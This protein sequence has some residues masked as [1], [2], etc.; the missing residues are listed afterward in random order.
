MLAESCLVLG[1]SRAMSECP[2]LARFLF[3]LVAALAF[4]ASTSA[5]Q[6][7][8]RLES[9][10]WGERCALRFMNDRFGEVFLLLGYCL[11]QALSCDSS[12][13]NLGYRR[14]WFSSASG[15]QQ[16]PLHRIE[17]PL[18]LSLV[19]QLESRSRS[20]QIYSRDP[21]NSVEGSH[22]NLPATREKRAEIHSYQ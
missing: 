9:T 20:S 2:P 5:H 21:R 15:A 8:T 12:P 17:P 19:P 18:T 11:P 14:H 10:F 6:H 3:L 13:L 22:D 16:P 4:D 1:A 7:L